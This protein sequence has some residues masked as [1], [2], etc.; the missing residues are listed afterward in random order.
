MAGTG[1]TA[2]A[3]RQELAAARISAGIT[4]PDAPSAEILTD[5]LRHR[6]TQHQ[7]ELAKQ[8]SH[9]PPRARTHTNDQGQDG[10]IDR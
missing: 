3:L 2:D 10:G 9:E 4:D 1:K 5:E 7:D 6:I 8:P